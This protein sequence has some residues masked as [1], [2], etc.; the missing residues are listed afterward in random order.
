MA[1]R[2]FRTLAFVFGFTT[3]LV[4]VVG[5]G[6]WSWPEDV[7]GSVIGTITYPLTTEASSMTDEASM[8]GEA[9]TGKMGM[10]QGMSWSMV[11]LKVYEA[12]VQESVSDVDGKFTFTDVVPGEGY[13]IYA[14][15]YTGLQT[16]ALWQDGVTVH[17]GITSDLGLLPL[18]QAGDIAGIVYSDTG[19][20]Q[21]VVL[22]MMGTRLTSDQTGLFQFSDVPYGPL[23]IT[24]SAAGY[25]DHSGQL[26]VEAESS[27]YNIYL[28][29]SGIIHMG[30]V[31]PAM[32]FSTPTAGDRRIGS[33]IMLSWAAYDPD[34]DAAITLYYDTDSSGADGI[35]IVSGL[36][37]S[38]DS[39][40]LWNASSL[41]PSSYYVYGLI[42][43]SLNEPVAIYSIGTITLTGQ[44][45]APEVA[46]T[47]PPT[48]A[49]VEGSI[50]IGWDASDADGDTLMISL[51]YSRD[52]G[53]TWT[54]MAFDQEN[55]G[56]WSWDTQQVPNGIAYRIKVE[57]TDGSLVSE[58]V[59]DADIAVRNLGAAVTFASNNLELKVRDALSIPSGDLYADD[60]SGLTVFDAS[61]STI[62]DISGLEHMT[63]LVEVDLSGNQI[64]DL[65]PLQQLTSLEKCDLG[66]NQVADLQPLSSL[67]ALTEL[68]LTGNEL[69]DVT[70]LGGLTSLQTLDLSEN[71]LISSVASLGQ[72]PGL[73]SL[74]V[75]GCQVTDLSGLGG[76]GSLTTLV[77][78]NNQI[79]D[80]SGLAALTG[81]TTLDVSNNLVSDITALAG[82]TGLGELDLGNNQ[83]PSLAVIAG[84][85]N[86]TSLDVSRNL[87]NDL[88]PLNSLPIIQTLNVS[89]NT[90]TNIDE[91][92]LSCLSLQELDLSNNLISDIQ[93]LVDSCTFNPGDIIDLQFNSLNDDSLN[94]H[95]PALVGQGITVLY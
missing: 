35:Q 89:S 68:V 48:G 90:L 40:Y 44:N 82:M 88:S 1:R 65:A 29:R 38:A 94:T 86:L 69:S 52:S 5:C 84:L 63:G 43:D 62:D 8:T 92:A 17:V 67:T 93:P 12:T 59:H 37:E 11:T 70:H 50:V 79:N 4:T 57:A 28:D 58:S 76:S 6:S 49:T 66:N 46:L 42:D 71:D 19:N 87:F 22:E 64:T 23:A 83:V 72:L 81:L 77:V 36:L 74:D 53:A 21:G 7:T 24:A 34:D 45:Q 56:S 55:D 39:S 3:L 95:V 10:R 15:K 9:A 30:N 27:T 2:V 14:R 13:N 91:L 16:Y 61:S 25:R 73:A 85:T 18:K 32:A 33:Q 26:T 54:L 78:D 20:I 80:I 41:T 31:P 51:Y 75:G 60:L 47:S